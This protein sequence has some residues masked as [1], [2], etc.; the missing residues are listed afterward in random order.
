[1]AIT[2]SHKIQLIVSKI[3]LLAFFLSS[4]IPQN[5]DSVPPHLCFAD[6]IQFDFFKALLCCDKTGGGNVSLRKFW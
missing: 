5:F 2:I 1:M 6:F 3:F 4:H